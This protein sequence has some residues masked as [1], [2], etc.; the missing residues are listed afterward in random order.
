MCLKPSD[1]EEE[2][3]DTVDREEALHLEI[4]RFEGTCGQVHRAVE[5]ASKALTHVAGRLREIRGHDVED[6]IAKLVEP[7]RAEVSAMLSVGAR[8]N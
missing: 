3:R 7:Y 1:A 8:E 6:L 2:A 4:I 5:S